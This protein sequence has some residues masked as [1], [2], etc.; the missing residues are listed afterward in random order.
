VKKYGVWHFADDATTD[1]NDS[2]NGGGKATGGAGTAPASGV[3]PQRQLDREVESAI[4]RY[5]NADMAIRR[6][7]SENFKLR[8]YRRDFRKLNAAE[9]APMLPEGMLVLDKSEADTYRSFQKLNL[10][11]SEVAS[12]IK[13]ADTL[14]QKVE[15]AEREALRREAAEIAGYNP[16]VLSRLADAEKLHIEIRDEQEDG[17]AIRKAY[18]RRAEAANDPLVP[19]SEFAENQLG[20]FLPSLRVEAS[21]QPDAGTVRFPQQQPA[22]AKPPAAGGNLVDRFIAQKKEAAAKRNNPLAPQVS[23]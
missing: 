15:Q 12:R 8:G 9:I 3:L 21:G 22:G 18:A 14:R 5:G 23:K 1:D 10:K 4:A 17:K 7:M 11:P 2:S 20:D 19:L 13:D 16:K 6:L